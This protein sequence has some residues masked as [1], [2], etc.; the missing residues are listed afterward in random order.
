M[1]DQS[2][3]KFHNLQ[4]RGSNTARNR[5][6]RALPIALVIAFL[7][8]TTL[9]ASSIAGHN[10][11][12]QGAKPDTSLLYVL[13]SNDGKEKS[14]VLAINPLTGKAVMKFDAY[15]KPDMALSLDGKR[16]FV[17][18]GILSEDGSTLLRHVLQVFDTNTGSIIRTIDNPDQVTPT[19]NQYSSRMAMSQDG[20]LLYVFRLIMDKD[21]YY[22]ATL[23]LDKLEFLP[24]RTILPY[25]IVGFLIPQP[26]RLKLDVMCSGTR[27]ISSLTIS[28]SGKATV[29]RVN[30]NNGLGR[31]GFGSPF[32][33]KDGRTLK[34]VTMEGQLYEVDKASRKLNG[35]PSGVT[36]QTE[37]GGRLN[38]RSIFPQ[39]PKA[40]SDS[41]KLYVSA[42]RVNDLKHGSPI[43]DMIVE[44]DSTSGAISR[45]FVTSKPIHSFA[46]SSDGHT[47]YAVEFRGNSILVI[48]IRSLREIRT[49][50]SIGTSPAFVLPAP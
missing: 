37:T 21:W 33:S 41:T 12:L 50:E 42:S 13:D 18:S 9:A 1:R 19:L 7:I 6:Q 46:I 8:F 31:K 4:P 38:E 43:T 16:L 10:A 2:K 34:L 26:E 14:Q 49:L 47:L 39:I 44:L 23:D 20:Q 48:D 27:D 11:F 17:A 15:Y 25:C 35:L 5:I 29:S 28:E 24:E 45:S 32:L 22:V 40:L 30:L 36:A 3:N